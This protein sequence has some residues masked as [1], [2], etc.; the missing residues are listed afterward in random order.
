[1]ENGYVILHFDTK[2]WKS[3]KQYN[4]GNWHYVTVTKKEGRYKIKM[5]FTC[6]KNVI[7]NQVMLTEILKIDGKC[8]TLQ[9][10]LA[11]YFKT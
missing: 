8:V 5:C 1:M 6:S 2:K 10:Q 9:L 4:D 7:R 11:Y 3:S